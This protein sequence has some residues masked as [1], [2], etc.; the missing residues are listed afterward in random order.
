MPADEIGEYIDRFNFWIDTREFSDEIVIKGG[1]LTAVGR[2]AFTLLKNSW[3]LQH[4][5]CL[6]SLLNFL[7]TDAVV[8]VVKA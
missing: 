6:E 3:E 7:A 8:V 2:E 4:E 5:Q 1:F